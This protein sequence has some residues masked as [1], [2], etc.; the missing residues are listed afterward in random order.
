MDFFAGDLITESTERL[1]LLSIFRQNSRAVSERIE[2]GGDFLTCR[3]FFD[4]RQDDAIDP[5]L[6]KNF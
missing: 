3:D 5:A 2:K 6:E 1:P 4:S